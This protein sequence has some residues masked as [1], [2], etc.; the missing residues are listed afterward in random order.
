MNAE[1]KIL[2]KYL[3]WISNASDMDISIYF[4]GCCL[5]NYSQRH[6]GHTEENSTKQN[7]R[8][9]SLK[10]HSLVL[11]RYISLR[12]GSIRLNSGLKDN[13]HWISYFIVYQVTMSDMSGKHIDD[14]LAK[15]PSEMLKPP[16]ST[17]ETLVEKYPVNSNLMVDFYYCND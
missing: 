13:N 6:L 11:S 1:H 15:I 9:N 12:F 3:N 10:K 4:T 5:M 17:N 8:F 7:R 14:F 16:W 2:V